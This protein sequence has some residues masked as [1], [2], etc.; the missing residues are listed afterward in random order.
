MMEVCLCRG[1]NG[2]GSTPP[3]ERSGTVGALAPVPR[4]RPFCEPLQRPS[5]RF[6]EHRVAGGSGEPGQ[7]GEVAA[8]PAP[9]R[10]GAAVPQ[11]G[12]AVLHLAN[13]AAVAG[14]S[15]VAYS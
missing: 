15:H 11:D 6:L 12:L 8:P 10:L 1:L 5:L 2:S 3:S 14:L 4:P 7:G 9:K 13:S